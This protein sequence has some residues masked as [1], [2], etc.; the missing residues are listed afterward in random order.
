MLE[1]VKCYDGSRKED[2]ILRCFVVFWSGDIPALSKLMCTTGHNSYKGCRYCNLH[3]VYY[4]YVY[5]PII[6]PKNS[7]LTKYNTKNLPKKSYQ[8]FININ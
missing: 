8:L 6:P 7:K 4:N 1:G 5:Y 3:G 2:F